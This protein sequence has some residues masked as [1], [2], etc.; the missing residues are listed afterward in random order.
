[1]Q[2]GPILLLPIKDTLASSPLVGLVVI[3]EGEI[4]FVE[5]LTWLKDKGSLPSLLMGAVVQFQGQVQIN[6]SRPTIDNID[7][8]L[9]QDYLLG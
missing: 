2:E 3:G 6:E 5:L 1:M 4:T 9:K 8:V 7:E